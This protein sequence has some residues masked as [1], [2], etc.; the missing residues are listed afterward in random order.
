M[1]ANWWKYGLC[2]FGGLGVGYIV[3]VK[4]TENK[5]EEE[6]EQKISDIREIYRNDRRAKAPKKEKEPEPEKPEI[7]TKT[8]IQMEKLSE[9]KN[10]AEQAMGTYSKPFK[11]DSKPGTDEEDIPETPAPKPGPGIKLPE[12][13]HLVEDFPDDNEYPVE[14]LKYHS[15]GILSR[16][17]NGS[18]V[19]DEDIPEMIGNPDVLK[20]LDEEECNQIKIVNDTW[21]LNYTIIFVYEPWSKIEE[22]E[23]YRK[24]L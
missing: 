21:G 12:H 6:Y 10:K 7:T 4:I 11:P 23:P 15:D 9:K 5:A 24:Q 3:G 16:S 18:M 13:I 1:A 14:V 2:V 8:S 22:E 20:L 19:D 17:V